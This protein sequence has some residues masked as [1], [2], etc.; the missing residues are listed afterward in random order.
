MPAAERARI[1]IRGGGAMTV[2]VA[3]PAV[4][5]YVIVFANSSFGPRK[6][7]LLSDG[8]VSVDDMPAHGSWHMRGGGELMTI[9]WSHHQDAW[10]GHRSIRSVMYMQV[11]GLEGVYQSLH[12]GAESAFATILHEMV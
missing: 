1:A 4:K 6:L 2:L 9:A 7:T 10:L 5:T 3:L 8:R 11:L 12:R